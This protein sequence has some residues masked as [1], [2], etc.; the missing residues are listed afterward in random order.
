MSSD[1]TPATWNFQ[2]RATTTEKAILQRVIDAHADMGLRISLNDALLVL[3]RR[4]ATPDPDTKEEAWRKIEQHWSS[5]PYG[6]SYDHVKCPEGWRLHDILHRT[7][8]P[9]PAHLTRR[10]APAAPE[11]PDAEVVQLPVWR[12]LFTGRKVS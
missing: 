10:P 7:P 11:R 9:L 5:C 2:L 4:S 1:I 8:G 3:I 12:R 6:C